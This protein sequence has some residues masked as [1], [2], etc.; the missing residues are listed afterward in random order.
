MQIAVLIL[1][2]TRDLHLS[3]GAIGLTYMFGGLGCVI[4]AAFA[5]RLSARF[6]VGPVIVHGLILTA[7]AWQAF[8]AG[9]TT[10]RLDQMQAAA[11]AEEA[12]DK[13]AVTPGPLAPARELYGEM[14]LAAGRT[15][16]AL[17]AFE[18]TMKKEPGR[19]RGT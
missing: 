13:A 7:L 17:A 2:A 12:T 6:G 16:E 5:E 14:L 4:A 8:A 19:F 11:D 9:R 18:S 3:A 10:E 1:F 15:Q